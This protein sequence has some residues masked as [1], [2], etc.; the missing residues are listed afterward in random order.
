MGDGVRRREI[1]G[2]AAGSPTAAGGAGAESA[3][4]V[5]EEAARAAM[6]HY[7]ETGPGVPVV[8]PVVQTAAGAVQGLVQDGDLTFRA[9]ATARRRSGRCV[10][11]AEPAQAWKGTTPIDFG[12]PAMQMAGGDIAD[13]PNDFGF[14]MHRVFTTPSEMKMMNEDC[15]YL[16]V[17]TPARRRPQAAGDGVD[18]RRRL[19]LRLGRPADL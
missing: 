7:V 19:R 3:K 4:P 8:T 18:P 14:Q 2:L 5:A 10:D 6:A 17:W 12:A 13:A 11:A 1:L 9:S 16:N 15:L